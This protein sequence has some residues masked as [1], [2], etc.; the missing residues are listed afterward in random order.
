[1]RFAALA[2]VSSLLSS[3]CAEFQIFHIRRF[4]PIPA[5]QTEALGREGADLQACLDVLGA[6]HLVWE[7]PRGL[8]LVYAWLDKV[9]WKFSVVV[10]GTD[11]A[12]DGRTLF[13]F[14]GVN[15]AYDGVVLVF[16]DDL[17][18][19]I[20]RRGLLGD[21]TRDLPRRPTFVEDSG[22]G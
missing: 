5:A 6:P 11:L 19:Q 14:N 4:E 8:T 13:S 18:L 1:M 17:D 22:G 15:N 7:S 12:I 10:Y 2:L 3:S 20:V 21:I 9:D 16:D